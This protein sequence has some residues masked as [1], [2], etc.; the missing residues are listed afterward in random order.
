MRKE[1][2]DGKV[3]VLYS[4]G[5]GAGWYS[6]HG[7]EEMLFDPSLVYMAEEMDKSSTPEEYKNWI[8]EIVTYCEDKY[9][10]VYLG[11]AEDLTVA[12][13]DEGTEF[14]IDEYDGSESLVVKNEEP[15]MK[16]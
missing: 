16:A 12:W 13:L 7:V 14:M 3:A 15:W 8:V 2:R 1:I 9:P 4:P 5:F 11:G 10:D 6:W